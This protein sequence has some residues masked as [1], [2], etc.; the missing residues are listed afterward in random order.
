MK[1]KI[2]CAYEPLT[3]LLD[4]LSHRDISHFS[5]GHELRLGWLLSQIVHRTEEL[6]EIVAKSI[7]SMR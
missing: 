5:P 3:S 2:N 6:Y 7:Q 1:K 4:S